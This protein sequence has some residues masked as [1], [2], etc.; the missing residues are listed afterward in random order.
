MVKALKSWIGLAH[1]G[2]SRFGLAHFRN[3]QYGMAHFRNS[4]FGLAHFGNSRFGAGPFKKTFEKMSFL[5]CFPLLWVIFWLLTLVQ[6]DDMDILQKKWSKT[7]IP[8]WNKS[9][10]IFHTPICTCSCHRLLCS[11]TNLKEHSKSA[12]SCPSWPFRTP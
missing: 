7:L 9:S 2:N 11:R 6:S 12:T 10:N 5:A 4:W 8:A 1:F 3:S